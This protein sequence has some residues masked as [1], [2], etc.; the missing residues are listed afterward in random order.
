MGL[1]PRRRK[2]KLNLVYSLVLGSLY[3]FFNDC[4]TIYIGKFYS[5]EEPS[6]ATILQ[7]RTHNAAFPAALRTSWTTGLIYFTHTCQV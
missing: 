5:W 4:K 1:S 3:L 6:S 7:R 2:R